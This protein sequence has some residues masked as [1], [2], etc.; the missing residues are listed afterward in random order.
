MQVRWGLL[1]LKCRRN[2]GVDE[3]AVQRRLSH[4]KNGAAG[5]RGCGGKPTCWGHVLAGSAWSRHE[6]RKPGGGVVTRQ[7][8]SLSRARV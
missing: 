6:I 8:R 4:L 5:Q 7:Y 3:S 1:R 2:E